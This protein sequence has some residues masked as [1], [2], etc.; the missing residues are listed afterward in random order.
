MKEYK[1]ICLFQIII[2]EWN[3]GKNTVRRASSARKYH[4]L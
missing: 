2:L 4:P 1:I 3:R